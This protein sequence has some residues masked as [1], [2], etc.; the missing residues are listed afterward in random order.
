MTV[1]PKRMF[2]LTYGALTLILVLTGCLPAPT[3]V[4]WTRS[5][6]RTASLRLVVGQVLVLRTAPEP[7]SGFHWIAKVS[8]P[9][10]IGQVGAPK[11]EQVDVNTPGGRHLTRF[12]FRAHA[13]GHA[14]IDFHFFS[15]PEF[16]ATGSADHFV[17][18]VDVGEAVR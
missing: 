5:N 4:E 6:E 12:D 2:P 3:Q 8:D 15:G 9:R 11:L 16:T 14:D 17:V 7:L 1:C 10:V 18:G 13:R